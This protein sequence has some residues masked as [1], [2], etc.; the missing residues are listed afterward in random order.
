MATKY[1]KLSMDPGSGVESGI[2]D[3]HPGS[4]TLYLGIFP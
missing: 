4:A 1:K 2:W 3:K